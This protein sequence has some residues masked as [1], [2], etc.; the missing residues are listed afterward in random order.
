MQLV[1]HCINGFFIYLNKE[2]SIVHYLTKN[3]LIIFPTSV[4]SVSITP[5]KPA[6][7][8]VGISRVFYYLAFSSTSA[9]STDY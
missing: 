5:T 7:K 8:T 9:L 2:Q 4:M 6:D 3:L 1:N